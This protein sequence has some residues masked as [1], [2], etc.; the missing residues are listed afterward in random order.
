MEDSFSM[1]GGGMTQTHDVDRALDFYYCDIS[2]TSDL[3]ALDPRGWGS[4]L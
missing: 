4:L 2:S 1:D 3:Q